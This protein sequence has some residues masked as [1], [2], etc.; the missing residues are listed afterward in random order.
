MGILNVTRTPSRRRSVLWEQPLP[1][2]VPLQV[3]PTS[4]TSGGVTRPGAVLFQRRNSGVAWSR[5]PVRDAPGSRSRSTRPMLRCRLAPRAGARDQRR[6]LPADLGWRRSW[7]FTASS[8]SCTAAVPWRHEGFSDWPEDAYDDVVGGGSCGVV[9]ARDR[10]VLR[11]AR[12]PRS[13]DPGVGF[14]K[15]ARHS[16]GSLGKMGVHG[17][18]APSSSERAGSPSAAAIASPAVSPLLLSRA[19][20]APSRAASGRWRLGFSGSTMSRP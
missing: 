14:A 8:S 20:V 6:L 15:N 4:S 7:R 19:S 5:R 11:G 2:E 10:A 17:R 1:A 13:T 16:V 12:R 3:A 18:G 9:R